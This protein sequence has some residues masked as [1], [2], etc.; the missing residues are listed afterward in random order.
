MITDVSLYDLFA[1]GSLDIVI[2]NFG[3]IRARP[4]GQGFYAG[5][6]V[7]GTLAD[8]GVLH[9]H[10]KRDVA[11]HRTKEFAARRR[12]RSFDDIP[13]RLFRFCPLRDF[14]LKVLVRFLQLLGTLGHQ[15]FETLPMPFQFGLGE[16]SAGDVDLRADHPHRP[17]RGVPFDHPAMIEHPPPLSVL[18]P[19]PMLGFVDRR[20]TF[21]MGG[22]R[23]DHLAAV[24]GMN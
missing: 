3:I 22:H 13:H 11:N 14:E 9:L 7:V 19:Q 1:R 17:P 8:V 18:G 4:G 24:V 23:F 5:L 2:H 6:R 15:H 12:A 16:F 21:E 20:F 10:R